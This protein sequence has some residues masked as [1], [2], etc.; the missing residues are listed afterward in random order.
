MITALTSTSQSGTIAA[1]GQVANTYAAADAFAD[2]TARRA[3]NTIDAQRADLASFAEYLCVATDGADCP[4]AETLQTTPAAWHGVTWGL[5]AGFV[6]WL[7]GQGAA[8]ATV[9]RKLSTVKVY[10]KLAAQAG[11]IGADDAAL[12]RTV[13]G[14]GRKEGKKVD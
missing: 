3:P 1:A 2:Y 13:T 9:N 5:V 10:A 14:Y 12:I 6:R 8:I 4:D 11:T 7:L